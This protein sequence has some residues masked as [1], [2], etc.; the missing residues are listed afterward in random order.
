LESLNIALFHQLLEPQGQDVLAAAQALQPRE[1]DFLSHY[2]ALCRDHPPALASAALEI[3][4]L[5]LEA[6][7]KFPFANKMYFTRAALE[8]ASSYEVSS[9]R[10]TRYHS[11]SCLFDLGCSIGSDTL[12]LANLG[13]T[14][15][16]DLDPLRLA[17]ARANLQ[18]LN[19]ED[20]TGWVQMDLRQSLPWAPV[21]G[22]GVFFDPA[23]RTEGKRVHSVQ[24]Y[25]PPLEIIRG[26]LDG[27]PAVGVKVSPA[28]DLAELR[29][30]D[31]EVEF[32][33]LR[34][35]LKEAVL[36]FGPL[37]TAVR[38]ATLLP[39][40][41]TLEG[42]ALAPLSIREPGEF[43][44]EPDPAVLRAGLVAAL[45]IQ[46][47]AEQLDPDIAYLT[48]DELISTPFARVWRVVDWFP[49][50]IKRLRTYLKSRGIGR[51]VVKKRGSPLEPDELIK[52]LK[53]SGRGEAWIF[54]THLRGKPV[55]LVASEE[56][57]QIGEAQ[58]P[59]S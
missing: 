33:S 29:N 32:I 4:I 26:W 18:A 8:Q 21:P 20:R 12:A 17:M 22:A 40:A 53:L 54:L 49:F 58:S 55:V 1:V 52:K 19:L 34:G 35:A 56:I 3:A 27:F 9:Y 47:G 57:N 43:I 28:V 25:L 2:Q 38:R 30:Y 23:R 11:Y 24:K 6:E 44:Y 16:A 37:K 51:V 45:G 48:S 13:L 15:G 59:A 50:G 42:F 39:G 7:E 46:L 36:W 41:F 14:I 10:S 31:A 5:R